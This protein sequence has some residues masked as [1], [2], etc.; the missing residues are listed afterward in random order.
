MSVLSEQVFCRCRNAIGVQQNK[1]PSLLSCETPALKPCVLL[2][3]PAG[4]AFPGASS[5]LGGYMSSPN[6]HAGPSSLP[7]EPAFRA[8]NNPPSLQMAQLW[9]SHS[10]EG[11]T[12]LFFLR[13]TTLSLVE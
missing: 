12:Q 3:S 13:A 7:S 6:A 11:M 5:F 4:D 9:A 2:S 1:T 10:H 8:P